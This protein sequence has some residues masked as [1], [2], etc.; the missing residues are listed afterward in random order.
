MLNLPWEA[1]KRCE[2]V[3]RWGLTQILEDAL[4]AFHLDGLDLDLLEDLSG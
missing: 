3:L 4:E 1:I 2:W